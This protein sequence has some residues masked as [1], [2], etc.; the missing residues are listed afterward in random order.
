[1]TWLIGETGRSILDYWFISHIAFWLVAGSTIA[2]L[3]GHRIRWLFI[4]L[5]VGLAWELFE[6]GAEK[7]WPGSWQSPESIVNKVGDMATVVMGLW[8]SFFG[9]DRWRTKK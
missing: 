6:I 2:A 3:K 7:W 1:M 5:A 9:F 4:C 8:I